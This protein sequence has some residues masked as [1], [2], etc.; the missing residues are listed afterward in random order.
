MK[1]ESICSM[2]GNQSETRSPFSCALHGVSAWE[3]LLRCP[4]AF[5]ASYKLRKMGFR[6]AMPT[7]FRNRELLQVISMILLVTFYRSCGWIIDAEIAHRPAIH[8]TGRFMVDLLNECVCVCRHLACATH[9]DNILS[10][11]CKSSGCCCWRRRLFGEHTC[12][13]QNVKQN[14]FHAKLKKKEK[15]NV[16]RCK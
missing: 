13:K 5:I 16:V 10:M 2:H 8:T 11:C 6:S 9:K 4:L 3:G 14:R 15:T 1:S 12:T 7:Q